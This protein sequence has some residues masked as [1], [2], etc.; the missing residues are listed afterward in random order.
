MVN[1]YFADKF[2]DWTQPTN[3]FRLWFS[4]SRP[5]AWTRMLAVR[6]GTFCN[7]TEWAGPWYWPLTSWTRLTCWVTASPSWWTVSSSAVEVHCF[8]R[9]NTVGELVTGK[10][11][12]CCCCAVIPWHVFPPKSYYTHDICIVF[13]LIKFLIF[14]FTNLFN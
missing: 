12:V 6:P 13:F 14:I 4:T 7:T 2:I 5:R 8:L 9:R 10:L 1:K 11:I 3:H